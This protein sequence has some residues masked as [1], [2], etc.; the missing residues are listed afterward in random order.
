MELTILRKI[1]RKTV[2]MKYLGVTFYSRINSLLQLNTKNIH[3]IYIPVADVLP[4]SQISVSIYDEGNRLRDRKDLRGRVKSLK[5]IV[6][7]SQVRKRGTQRGFGKTIVVSKRALRP[8]KSEG[9]KRAMNAQIKSKLRQR[10][11]P[12]QATEE[13]QNRTRKNV[14]KK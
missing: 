1:C 9:T 8:R 2:R 13:E 6:L 3:I 5:E 14:K 12:L 7:P 4:L 11:I 10:N